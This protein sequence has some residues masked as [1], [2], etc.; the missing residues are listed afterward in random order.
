MGAEISSGRLVI[1]FQVKDRHESLLASASRQR[2]TL[3]ISQ[4]LVASTSISVDYREYD[5]V[6]VAMQRFEMLVESS[7]SRSRVHSRYCVKRF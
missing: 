7:T 3:Q 6:S 1:T 4:S 2:F 5:T